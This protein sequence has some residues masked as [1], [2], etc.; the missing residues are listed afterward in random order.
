MQKVAQ[1]A[2]RNSGL[3][4]FGRAMMS[5]ASSG[6]DHPHPNPHHGAPQ[7]H[8]KSH[9]AESYE[10]AFFYEPGAYTEGL[11]ALVRERLQLNSTAFKISEDALNH[12][13]PRRRRVLLDIGGGT[14][15]FTRM[16]V[17]DTNVSAIVVDPFLEQSQ[18]GNGVENVQFVAERAEAFMATQKDASKEVHD[19]SD[20]HGDENWW[21]HN[22]DCILLKEVAHHFADQDRKHIFRGMWQG[23]RPLQKNE[24]GT[25]LL[26]ITRPQHD[27]DYP[28][29][30]EARQVWAQNQPS[31]ETFV[32]ELQEAGFQDIHHTIE[33]FPCSVSLQR[34]QSMVKQRFWSTFSHFSDEQLEEACERIAQN[35]QHRIHDGVIEFEDRLVFL[36][37]KKV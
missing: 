30:D 27:I 4:C 5:N 11:C 10:Q 6:A 20:Q 17:K 1:L 32:A 37:A 22:Y 29:W 33:T 2:V 15:N 12:E 23:L 28:L 36:S 3:R 7:A 14:G 34:W 26:L 19:N 9:S 16:I 35:E 18:C 31:L 8:Y 21:K 24:S 25:S 13:R